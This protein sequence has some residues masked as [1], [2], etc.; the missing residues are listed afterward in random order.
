MPQQSN[1]PLVFQAP[2]LCDFASR[3]LRA[4]GVEQSRADLVAESLVAANL[5][6]VDSHGLH[7]LPAYIKQIR[8]GNI[9]VS[10]DGK[11]LTES[12][13]C[14][15]YDGMHGLGQCVSAACCGH[16]A[17][18]ASQHGVGIAIARNSNHFG[19]AAFWAQRI[20]GAG[21]IG[22]AMCNASP[23]V[24]PWQG[25]QGRIG[26]NPI[27]VSVPST[28][29]GGWL[30][31]MATTTVAKNRVIKASTNGDERIPPGWAMDVDGVPT[32]DT[33]A[34]MRGLLMPLGG[35]KG[36]GLGVMV[37]IL[38]GVLS[39]GALAAE[40][41]GLYITER[42]MN[43]SQTFIAIDV[44]R[45]MPPDSFQ[46]RMERLVRSLKATLPARGYGEI[47]VAGD[48]EWRSETERQRDGIP[49]EPGVWTK[50][51]GMALELG[52][53]MPALRSNTLPERR[54]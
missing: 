8:A 2:T 22:V 45:F 43:T 15:L 25:R 47:L 36:S 1:S 23:S 12:G 13:A 51:E 37:E 6:G 16:A 54:L 17:R 29:E 31:D 40:V 5:R 20:S 35:Y 39:G 41:G 38:C 3:A 9:D 49:I 21:F 18:L 42:P 33:A 44:R 53:S 7:I 50:L 4:A 14:V 30:L 24:P 32:T 10:A 26:T 52:I 34:A 11:V 48:P 46:E 27:S 28:G 19:A